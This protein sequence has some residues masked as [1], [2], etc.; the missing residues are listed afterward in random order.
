[1]TKQYTDMNQTDAL[2]KVAR[3][4]PGGLETLAVRMGMSVNVLR[5]KLAPGIDTHYPSFEEVAAIVEFLLE[6]KV[7][8][9]L[10]P[11]HAFNWR[12]GLISMAIPSTAHLSCDEIGQQVCRVMKEFGD[13]A[14]S[15]SDSLADNKITVR[16]RDRFDREFLDAFAALG[17]LQQRMHEHFEK[18]QA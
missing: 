10:L 12:L 1:M 8:D 15:I 7:A 14:A 11:V 18:D 17:Q 5:N 4:Y 2:Y 16:E 3:K 6:A 9:A 13:V